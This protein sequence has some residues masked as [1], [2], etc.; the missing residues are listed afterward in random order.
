MVTPGPFSDFSSCLAIPENV[1]DFRDGVDFYSL[2]LSDQSQ[3]IGHRYGCQINNR[4]A[5]ETS[6]LGDW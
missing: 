3:W 6:G 1:T 2:H 5:E 4:S